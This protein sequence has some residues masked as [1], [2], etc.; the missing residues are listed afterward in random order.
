MRILA[1]LCL[2]ISLALHAGETG[3]AFEGMVVDSRSAGMGDC[4]SVSACG[5]LCLSP[6]PASGSPGVVS[7]TFCS[8]FGMDELSQRSVTCSFRLRENVLTFGFAGR[9]SDLHQEGILSASASGL[10]TESVEVS[11]CL[12]LYSMFI[13]NV[14]ET[15]LVGASAGARVRPLP[16]LEACVGVCNP[17]TSRDSGTLPR[18]VLFAL[19]LRP[20]SNVTAACE[21]RKR[22]TASS[23]LHF[24]V[25]LEPEQGIRLR[26]GVQ[27]EPVELTLG[28]G[29]RLGPVGLE[30][31]TS[32]H[33]VLGRTDVFTLNWPAK[34][35]G[36]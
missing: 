28:F 8:P 15:R 2:C 3:A 21:M 5:A 9:G 26:C 6:L 24:G 13:E 19:L 33:S 14:G 1:A 18:G 34:A 16:Q 25:E 11:L 17:A 23:C 10:L 12:G 31:A 29:L 30:T 20:A 4:L 7:F 32:F 22:T 27:T 36:K 35:R